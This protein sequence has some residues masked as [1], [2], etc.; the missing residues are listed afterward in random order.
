MGLPGG[1]AWP[2]GIAVLDPAG[3]VV[4]QP[5]DLW[6][7]AARVD[8]PDGGHTRLVSTVLNAD[9]LN[10]LRGGGSV[11]LW[12]NGDRPL[13][14][15]P[16][17]FWRGG[18]KVIADHPIMDALPHAGFVDLQ[19]YGLATPW[20]LDPARLARGRARSERCPLAAAAAG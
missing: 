2:D 11:L 8:A 16:G 15:V 13:P 17:P 4:D 18:T 20:S 12:Q 9:V 6:E 1:E 5:A 10:F 7:T 19:Y 3:S 14:V